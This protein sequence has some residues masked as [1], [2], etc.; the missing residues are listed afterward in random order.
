MTAQ[1]TLKQ[2]AIE[3]CDAALHGRVMYFL[4][5]EESRDCCWRFSIGMT[6]YNSVVLHWDTYLNPADRNTD[7]LVGENNQ[8]RDEENS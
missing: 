8:A 2:G 7:S 4:G 5:H 1:L 6:T 3:T